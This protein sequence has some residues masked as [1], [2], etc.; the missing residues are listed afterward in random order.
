VAAY[1]TTPRILACAGS[2]PGAEVRYGRDTVAELILGPMLRHVGERDAT[3]WVETDAACRV[4]VLGHETP[5]FHVAGH[6]YAVVTIDGLTPGGTFEYEVALDGERRWPAGGL[7]P[8]SRIRTL[9]RERPVAVSFGSCRIAAPHEQPY[10]LERTQHPEGRGVDALQALAERMRR[11][12]PDEWPSLLVM[13]GDQV[14]ADDA[15]PQTRDF[16]RARR[17]TNAPPGQAV[18]DFEEYTR[19]YREAWSEPATRWLLSTLPS[20]MIFDDHEVID[21][22]N[23]SAAWRR[24]IAAQPWWRERIAGAFMSYWLYQH[25]GNQ[26]LTEL[27]EDQTYK[28][29]RSTDDA[30]P[31]LHEFALEA[32]RTTDNTRWSYCRTLGRSRLVVIDSRAGRRF[33]GGRREMLDEAEWRWLSDQLQ[34]DIDHLLVVTSLP[35]LLP[36]AIHDLEAWN[37]AVCA[38]AWGR[39]GARVAERVRRAIDLEHWASFQASFLRLANILY[40]VAAG[41]RGTPPASIVLMSG[42]VHYAYLAEAQFRGAPVQS[43]LYQ[44]VCSPFRHCLDPHLEL[45]NRFAC[46]GCGEAVGEILRRAAGVPP[47]PLSWEISHGPFFDNEIATLALEGRTARLRLER[48]PPHELGLNCVLDEPL[49]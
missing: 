5:T 9:D 39:V 29:V 42:D 34:G 6:H 20:A 1:A 26:S 3:V 25:L 28:R 23:I 47:P 19:L 13:L 43:R 38:G 37:E 30:G 35:F 17:S 4:E 21:D 33:D 40:E 14:Y 18:A 7:F 44:A 45:A 22:W 11:Q 41:G 16:I 48:T 2:G 46:R 27:A 8:P 10:V 24:D 31:L 32:D 36:R 15:S 12:P 49:T